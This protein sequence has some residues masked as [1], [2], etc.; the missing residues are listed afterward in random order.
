[1]STNYNF[2]VPTRLPNGVNHK[3]L[4]L[5]IK[6]NITSGFVMYHYGD[7]LS[8]IFDT[9]LSSGEETT[10][11]GLI[12]NHDETYVIPR[13]TFLSINPLIFQTKNSSYTTMATF[14]YGGAFN[15]GTINYIDI[16]AKRTNP[17][18]TYDLRIVDNSNGK[19][20]CEQNDLNNNDYQAIDMGTISNIPNEQTVLDVQAKISGSGNNKYVNLSQILIYYNN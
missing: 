16:L 7:N 4:E 14:T 1:M 20:L 13:E 9:A 8:I 12:D 6:Q 10:L 18:I 11:N 3:T 19:V 15:I 5:E 17:S 2:N